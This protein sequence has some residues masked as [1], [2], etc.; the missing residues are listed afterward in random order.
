[1]TTNIS[2]DS[3]IGVFD[4]GLGGL[5][6]LRA[7]EKILPKESFLYFGDTAHVPYGTKS[8][9]TVT[10]YS[11]HIL[12]FFVEHGT[13][14]VVIA[15]NTASAVACTTLQSEYEVPVF[16]VVTPSV[17]FAST[18]TKT[19]SVGVIGTTATVQSGAYTAAF[20]S[21]N[22]GISVKEIS[23][24]LF[25]PLIEEGWAETSIAREVAMQYLSPLSTLNTDTLILGCTHYPIM[26]DT[27]LSAVPGHI[28]LVYSGETVGEQLK[29]HLKKEEKF[30]TENALKTT[31]FFVSDFPQKFDELGS[32]FLGRPLENVTHVSLL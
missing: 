31:R 8:A 18:I 6:V 15:C 13:K 27:I 20:N 11:R 9:E 23:C 5:T 25:V 7:L 2:S 16:N 24:P 22:R 30:N 10:Q 32:R 3:P 4:S 1:M 29:H 26:A 21:L 12:D 28:Q 17:E 19:Q 14:A